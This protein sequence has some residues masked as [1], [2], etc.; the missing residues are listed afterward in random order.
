[1]IDN[2]W[3]R[4]EAKKGE[5][6]KAVVSEIINDDIE[7]KFAGLVVTCYGVDGFIPIKEALEVNAKGKLSDYYAVGDEVIAI[8]TYINPREWK[9]NLSINRY[10]KEEENKKT[11]S[12]LD[13]QDDSM[14]TIGD[15]INAD[16][17]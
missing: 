7:D 2:P 8:V 17:K 16:L 12:L 4:V 1:M 10:K 6:T 5:V 14:P 13:K 9:L 3:S 15:I 11:Q